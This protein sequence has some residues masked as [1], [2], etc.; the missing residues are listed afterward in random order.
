MCRDKCGDTYITHKSIFVHTFKMNLAK[1]TPLKYAEDSFIVSDSEE[2]DNSPLNNNTT[3][4]NPQIINDSDSEV[5]SPNFDSN[6]K[7]SEDQSSNDTLDSEEEDRQFMNNSHVVSIVQHSSDSESETN[8]KLNKIKRYSIYDNP[9]SSNSMKNERLNESTPIHGIKRKRLKRAVIYSD[10]ESENLSVNR[11]KKSANKSES[12][13]LPYNLD[14]EHEKYESKESNYESTGKDSSEQSI[15]S[16]KETSSNY[17]DSNEKSK[18]SSAHSL[19]LGIGKM[20]CPEIDEQRSIKKKDRDFKVSDLKLPEKKKFI[21]EERNKSNIIASSNVVDLTMSDDQ[22][23]FNSENTSYSEDK[24]TN[25]VDLTVDENSKNKSS[26][27]ERDKIKKNQESSDE[28]LIV[29]TSTSE[30]EID[31][32]VLNFVRKEVGVGNIDPVEAQ[33]KEH[34]LLQVDMLQNQLTKL[35]KLADSKAI[36][37]LPDRGAKVHETIKITQKKILDLQ[38]KLSK[39]S[40]RSAMKNSRNS[41]LPMIKTNSTINIEKTN[42]YNDLFNEGKENFNENGNFNVKKYVK[43]E[44]ESS[45]ENETEKLHVK[46]YLKNE[47]KSSHENHNRKL[48]VKKNV[49]SGSESDNVNEDDFDVHDI[50]DV[51]QT[52]FDPN[53]LGKKALE[54]LQKQ[55]SLTGQKLEQLHGSLTSRPADDV[56]DKDPYG[57]KIPLMVHQQHALAWLK[58]REQQKPKGGILADDMGLGKTLTMIS[59]VL[60]NLN[61]KESDSDNNS[62]SDD[63]WFSKKKEHKRYYGGTLVV[64]PA[65]LIKQWEA[66]VNNRC[67]RGLLSVLVFHGNKRSVDDRKLSKY[68]IVVTT[69]QTLVREAELESGMYKMEWTRVILDEAHYI[70]NHKSKACL[71]VCGLSSKYRWALTGTPIQ[72]K[73]MDLYAILKFLKCSPFD[74]LH[75]W[76]RWVDN[77]ND[78]G[79]QRLIT[80]MKTLMLRRT[81]QELQSKGSLESLPEKFIDI[82]EIDMDPDETLAYQKIL[83]FSQNL[84]AQFLAQRADKQHTKELYGG[85]FDRQNSAVTQFT[86]AQKVLLAH[87]SSI[88][89]YEILVLLLRLRQMCCHPA[90][91]HAM[92]DKEDAEVNGILE[93]DY[94]SN[95]ELLQRLSNISINE[96][97]KVDELAANYK[98]DEKVAT[99]LLS[100]KNPVFDQYRRSSKV[101]KIIDTVEEIVKKGE[102]LIIVSQWSSFLKVIAKNLDNIEDAKYEFFTGEVA[103]KKRQDI[104][105]KINNLRSD[106]NILLL[107]LTAGGV[108]LNLVGANHL[109]LIDIHW[110]PQLEA[111][112]Q[113]RIYRFGQKKNVHV[114]KFICKETIEERVKALQDKKL[115]VANHVLTGSRSVSSK[116]TIEDLKLLFS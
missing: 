86:K 4:V 46:K 104:V 44:F 109:L 23:E 59:L 51:P 32:E 111:Q 100:T 98:I 19:F 106:I 24:R 99:N 25:L 90:L 50:P 42:S 78:A 110:N 30:N 13:L 36:D 5:D 83:L 20:G 89:A 62:S 47:S 22:N 84:F 45:D 94:D 101:R 7:V 15:E 40:R 102:K 43:N 66:E 96:D 70:R 11:G 113:D 48:Y 39:L 69:Y 16:S 18:D 108:G 92:L 68:N 60:A 85:K 116:L 79:K 64:C 115:D 31:D 76:K 35:N 93:Q 2:E 88:E 112:A 8:N 34:Y 17:E 87:H 65:S 55:Q 37:K 28:V 72:N 58:W 56:R 105:D 63:E 29:S 80:I 61:E 6:S 27:I 12:K 81:K 73:E 49:N 57:L 95:N 9:D 53:D 82:V 107:S 33:K 1:I 10:S 3:G 77:K 91:V 26:I 75:V 71:A 114:Y 67:K 97:G 103:V 74:D 41:Q 14:D 38:A 21:L 52:F 54:T